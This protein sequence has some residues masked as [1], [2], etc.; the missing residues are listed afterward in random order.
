MKNFTLILVLFV[1]WSGPMEFGAGTEPQDSDAGKS[2]AAASKNLEEQKKIW[3][4]S[5]RPAAREEEEGCQER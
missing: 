5:G 2:A 4:R 3:Q 1:V